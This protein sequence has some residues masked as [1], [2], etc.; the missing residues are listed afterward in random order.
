M[1]SFVAAVA[2]MIGGSRRA[3][4]D[5]RRTINHSIVAECHSVA[6]SGRAVGARKP[7]T[8]GSG[9]GQ[10]CR[11]RAATTTGCRIVQQRLSQAAM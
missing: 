4:R 7:A 2:D 3:R 11:E 1:E 8:R 10:T 6:C 9:A 5:D